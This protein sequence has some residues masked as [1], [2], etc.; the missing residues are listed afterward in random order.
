MNASNHHLSRRK[1][2]TLLAKGF[3][4]T[5]GMGFLPASILEARES[6]PAMTITKI[7]G[8]RFNPDIK[9]GGGSGGADGAEFFWVRLHTDQGIVGIGETYPFSNGELGALKDYSRLLIGR[10]P[11]DIDGIWKR[12]YHDMSMRNAGGADMR[13]LSAVNMAQLDIL[14]IATGQ[15]LY[16]LLGGKSREQ[17]KVYNTVTDYW[18]INDMKMASDTP[19]I[20]RF[21][22]DRG[23]KAMKIY[24]FEQSR[25]PYI[26]HGEIERGLDWIREIREEAGMDMDICIDCWGRYDLAS[27]KRIAKALEPYNILYMEDVMLMN[28]AKAYAS[29]VQETSVPICHSETL[30]TRYEY[31]EFLELGACDV[32]MFDLSWCG[33]ITEAK[34]ISDFADTYLIPVSP[35]TAGGPLLWAASTHLMTAVPNFMIMESNYWK[36]SHQYP[37]FI[38]DIPTPV[39]G[40]VVAPEKPGL[41][42]TIREELFTSGDAIIETIAE[43]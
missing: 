20:T 13:I 35:H 39:N 15:P 29:L 8:I 34:K 42:V 22:L 6:A 7:E 10:D 14:G 21:L 9:I 26:T 28:N 27:A 33:G 36:Y 18:A 30:A 32:V 31:R 12:M 38:E 41:G 1:F 2:S 11:R 40:Y 3:L 24:P 4:G 5:V 37:Y 19:A 17:I 23:I 25:G 43:K 16:R